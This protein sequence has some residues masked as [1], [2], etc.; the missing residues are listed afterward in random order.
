MYKGAKQCAA[1]GIPA[2]RIYWKDAKR[3]ICWRCD[4]LL[5]SGKAA[6][7]RTE[8][9]AEHPI[10]FRLAKHSPGRYNVDSI[11][12]EVSLNRPDG[13][14]THQSSKPP[15]I[16]DSEPRYT[17]K[18]FNTAINNFLTAL[19]TGAPK[20]SGAQEVYLEDGTYSSH[21]DR[22]VILER[23]HAIAWVKFYDEMSQFC[24]GLQKKGEENGKNF[25]HALMKKEVDLYQ[26]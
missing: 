1:C 19:D 8:S 14:Y 5:E 10:A 11:Q 4:D 15:Y 24:A 17:S 12:D 2:S 20:S 23:K 18:Q 3:A 6:K 7:A 21:H 25:L 26:G 16:G 9:A 13:R 22:H